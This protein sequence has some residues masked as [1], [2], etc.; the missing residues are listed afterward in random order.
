[1]DAVKAGPESHRNL[2]RYIAAGKRSHLV[3]LERE[4]E[5]LQRYPDWF[6]REDAESL[7]VHGETPT[8]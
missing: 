4:L 1:M 2:F 6:R 3:H 8:E 5:M 7:V